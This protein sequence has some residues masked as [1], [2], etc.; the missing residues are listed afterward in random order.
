MK[1]LSLTKQQKK[2]KAI[3]V[4]DE[5]VNEKNIAIAKFEYLTKIFSTILMI[6]IFNS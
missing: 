4:D 6:I 1:L 3:I 5:A 2:N